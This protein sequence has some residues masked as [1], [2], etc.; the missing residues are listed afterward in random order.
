MPKSTP[1]KPSPRGQTAA[2]ASRSGQRNEGEGSR[3]AA[4]RYDRGVEKTVRSGVVPAKA[5]QAARALEGPEGR[6]LR[7][8]EALAKRGKTAS[9]SP[10]KVSRRPTIRRIRP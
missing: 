8:A 7:R 1:R 6:E 9:A 3:T 10:S 4:R 5:R 2:K